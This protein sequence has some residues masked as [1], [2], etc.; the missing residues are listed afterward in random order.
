MAD[1]ET[2]ALRKQ[3]AE[4]QR[5]MKVLVERTQA[6]GEGLR[7][8]ARKGSV[9][10]EMVDVHRLAISRA[11]SK[12]DKF[13]SHIRERGAKHYTLRGLAAAVRVAPATLRAHRI[14][15]GKPNS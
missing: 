3:L 6:G 14:P 5:M 8:S 1:D 2:K 7:P 13:L 15:K 4:L 11:H 10:N 12:S 9:N